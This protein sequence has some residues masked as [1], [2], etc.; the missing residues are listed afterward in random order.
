MMKTITVLGGDLYTLAAVHLGDATQWSRIAQ[1]N[2]IND[3]ILSGQHTLTIP[4][5]D[6]SQTGGLPR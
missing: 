1:Q 4:D 5:P 6:N 2:R 3:P